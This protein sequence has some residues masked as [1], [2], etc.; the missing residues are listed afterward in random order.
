MRRPCDR[1]PEENQN[2]LGINYDIDSDDELNEFLFEEIDQ[3]E[4]SESYDDW[5]DEQG[6]DLELMEEG[7]IND[8]DFFCG[9]EFDQ[10]KN[11]RNE[12]I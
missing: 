11:D 12:R 7:F 6:N 8:D 5:L 2:I 1:L 10:E 3:D 4:V 9:D